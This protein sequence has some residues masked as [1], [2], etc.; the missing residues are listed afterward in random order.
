MG[1]E[2]VADASHGQR[3]KSCIFCAAV[4]NEKDFLTVQKSHRCNQR[5]APPAAQKL[6]RHRQ[7]LGVEVTARQKRS[8][9]LTELTPYALRE[10]VKA[11]FM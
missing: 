3:R 6:C 11:V 8:S 1:T 5:R 4:V 10:L 2:N 7:R 9:E